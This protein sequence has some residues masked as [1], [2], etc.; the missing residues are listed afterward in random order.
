MS[1]LSQ[2]LQEQI[3]AGEDREH[4]CREYLQYSKDLLVSPDFAKNFI[5]VETERVEY[6]GRSDYIV[7]ADVWRGGDICRRA[8]L[9]ELKAPQRFIYEEDTNTRLKPTREFIDAENKLLNYYYN[10]RESGSFRTQYEIST[11]SNVSL[12]GII[13]GCYRTRVKTSH[14]SETEKNSLYNLAKIIRDPLYD[15]KIKLRTWDEILSFIA[16]PR[17]I[18]AVQDNM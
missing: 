11:P 8:Y 14:Y 10:L 15:G 12:G 18:D 13:I 6:L 4:E 5:N 16:N 9:W 7:I 2:G 1:E 17:R 3:D